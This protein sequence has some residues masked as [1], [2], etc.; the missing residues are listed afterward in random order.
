ME[1]PLSPR[2]APLSPDRE[3]QRLRDENTALR[4]S[5]RAAQD[6]LEIVPA[7]VG[8]V[9]PGGE[10]L[11]LN[12][13][14]LDVIG[15][16]REQIVGTRF[17]EAAWWAPI[18][19]SAERIQAAVVQGGRGNASQFDVQYWSQPAGSDAGQ[20]RWVA[21][22]V[23]PLAT[24]GQVARIGISGIDITD[25]KQAELELVAER[26]KLEEIFRESP[27]AMAVWRGPHLVF[28]LVNPRYQEIFAG[29]KLVGLPLLE[30]CPELVGQPFAD[31]LLKVL[32]TG[33]PFIGHEMLA[34]I[35]SP[36]DGTL[37]D[38]YYDFMYL[39]VNDPQGNPWGIYDHAVDVTE[40]VL[41]RRALE[42]SKQ[43]LEDAVRDLE[44]ERDL[45][46]RF[47]AA[48]THDLRTPL[49]AAKLSAQLLVQRE[50]DP[51]RLAK[52]AE[53]IANNM[54]RADNMIRDL[55]DVSRIKAGQKLPLDIEACDLTEI[56]RRT[57]EDIETIHGDRFVLT[58]PGPIA[59]H[60]DAVAI[61]RIIEN[62]AANGVKYGTPGTP[63][64]VSLDQTSHVVEITVHNEGPPIPEADQPTLFQLF[65]RTASA[66]KASQ[67]GWGVGLSLVHGLVTAQGGEVAVESAPRA[68]TTFTVR[69][70]RD[71]R[72]Y[73][74]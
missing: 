6:L 35:A 46:E 29:R 42:Q 73:Q 3:L 41:A 61:S 50:P 68:G 58:T 55:L 33:E 52:A 15:A 16:T 47:V 7:F 14:A 13:L 10:V 25:R 8:Y 19:R 53:R 22:S 23:T 74:T 37:E 45:R 67:R 51:A 71:A 18:P 34:R 30:A 57:L 11:E 40:R 20:V 5:L 12:Q 59:G 27:A 39:R 21:I 31:L 62:L 60:W 36:H 69:L 49:A 56:A 43:R 38:R 44:E 65:K 72:L 4:T 1:P 63:I 64:V 70:P 17:W 9:A 24:A 54:D 28:E 32:E 2:S 26:H 48:L 66:D